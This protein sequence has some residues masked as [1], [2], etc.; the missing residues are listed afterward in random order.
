M[1]ELT[2]EG[3]NLYVNDGK[4]VFEDQSARSGLGPRSLPYTGFGTA[5][6]DFDN[7]GW[8]DILTVNGTIA[9]IEALQRA[10]DPF[11]LHQRKQLFRNLG[12]GQ[13]Q[14]VT[15][16][17]GAAFRS[18]DVGRGAAFGDVDN[19]GDVDVLVGNDAGRTRLLINDIGSRKHWLG[20]RLLGQDA[21]RDLYGARVAVIRAGGPV[22]WRRARADG[23]YASASDPR[24]LVGLGD[25]TEAPTI[26]VI[27]PSGRVE[28]WMRVT[29]DRFTTLREGSGG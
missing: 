14:D 7:D 22:L 6:F 28:E 13:F 4:A 16:R 2:G 21:S 29:I 12:N 15:D 5:W 18:S 1:T 27:W 9:A 19:D 23:S 17:A 24:V 11:P 20:L 10:H 8:L 26:R 25:S 3:S